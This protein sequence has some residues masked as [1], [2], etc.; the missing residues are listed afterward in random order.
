MAASDL[1]AQLKEFDEQYILFPAFVAAKDA[2]ESNL[3]LFRES[4][5]A[6]HMLVSGEAGTG[7]TSL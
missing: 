5:V 3:R 6:K 2:I 7:K 1:Y 4:G